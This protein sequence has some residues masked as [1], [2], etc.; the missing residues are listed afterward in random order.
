MRRFKGLLVLLVLVML[1]SA[2]GAP[3]AE[4]PA[5]EAPA[6]GESAGSDAAPAEE[7]PAASEGSGEMG[8][9]TLSVSFSWPTYIDPAVGSDFSSSSSLTNLYD[10]LV[11]PTADGNVIP[12][13]AES[14]EASDDGLVWTFKLRQD[15]TF[16]DGSPL[17]A[18]DVVYS[19]NRLQTVGEGYGYMFTQVAGVSAV[20]DYTVEFTL[21]SGSGLFLPSLV[22]LYLV[23]ED[24]VEANIVADGTYGDKGDYAKGWLLT[25]DAGSGPYM[26]EAFQLEESLSMTKFDGWWGT[27]ADNAPAKLHFIAATE[28]ATIQTLMANG[29]LDISDQWQPVESLE[30]LDAMDGVSVVPLQSMSEFF[31]MMNTKIA[32]FDD[33][34]CRRAISW[35]YDY[36]SAVSLE[37]PGTPQSVGPVPQ[38]LG[39]H[40]ANVTQYTRDLEKAQAELDQCQYGATIADYPIEIHWISEVPAEEKFALLFQANMADLGI[41]VKVVS[42]PWL[43]VVENTGAQESSPDIVMI[44]IPSDLP[45]AGPM[46]KQRY[47]SSSAATWSQNEW[48][49]DPELDAEIDDALGTIDPTERFAKYEALQAKIVDLAP[50]LFIYDQSELH[51]YQD[52]VDWPAVRGESSSVTGYYLFAATIGLNK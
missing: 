3:A 39:G 33:V 52:W 35:A 27:F 32:P 51:A 49:L 2:C 18:S 50:S 44:Y 10:T 43:T 8:G 29:E 16:H 23:N 40:N 5:A 11:F 19:M 48:I 38:S 12:W 36:T 9:S 13:V 21:S 37:W 7:A 41:T 17:M 46:L 31:F 1:V 22:R 6:A 42:S 26:V 30:A 15:V 20:D 25:N 14:W 47:H 34:H 45:E 28:P 24:A 4:T